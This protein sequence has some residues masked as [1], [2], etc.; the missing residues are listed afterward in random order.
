MTNASLFVCVRDRETHTHTGYLQSQCPSVSHCT[1]IN[2]PNV[3][4]ANMSSFCSCLLVTLLY[5]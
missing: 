1:L 3:L 5:S 4:T 2:H